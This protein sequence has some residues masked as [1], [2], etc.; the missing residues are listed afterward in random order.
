MR[1]VY[2]SCVYFA[3]KF[4]NNLR[5]EYK[6]RSYFRTSWAALTGLATY[7]TAYLR[8][9]A[10]MIFLLTKKNKIIQGIGSEL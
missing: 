1:Y 6:P 9:C 10:S 2:K 4:H 3:R 8:M 7:T 5:A